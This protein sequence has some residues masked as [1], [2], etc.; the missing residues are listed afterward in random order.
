MRILSID[1]G[2]SGGLA[3]MQYNGPEIPK[4]VECLS[5]P[6]MARKKDGTGEAVAYSVLGAEIERLSPELVVLER[7]SGVASPKLAPGGTQGRPGTAGAFNFG[8]GYGVIIGVCW[9]LPQIYVSPS[10]WKKRLG[11][12]GSS[13]NKDYARTFALQRFPYCA[14]QLKRKKDVGRAEA[15]LI[16]YDYC[17]QLAGG[18]GLT[19]ATSDTRKPIALPVGYSMEL[20][21]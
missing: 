20:A 18:A 17:L 7:A 16:G 4:V 13:D 11:I 19:L 1:P 9:K 6:V 21:L 10:S 3:L 2:V 12:P 5:M 8:A 14:E 15:I